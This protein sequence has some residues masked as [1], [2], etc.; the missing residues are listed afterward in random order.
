MSITIHNSGTNLQNTGP[1]EFI[2]EKPLK[3]DSWNYRLQ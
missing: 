2:C 3:N 1:L